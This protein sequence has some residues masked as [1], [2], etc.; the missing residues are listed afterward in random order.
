M[1]LIM[2]PRVSTSPAN[3]PR[4]YRG[5]KRNSCPKP[6]IDTDKLTHSRLASSSSLP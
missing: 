1:L 2:F 3:Y 5:T 6:K 4:A